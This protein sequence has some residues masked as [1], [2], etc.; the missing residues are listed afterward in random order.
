MAY[1][2]GFVCAVP[3]ANKQTY[4]DHVT[5]VWPMFRGYGAIRMVEAWGTDIPRGKVTDFHGAVNA[6]DDEAIVF[7][8]IE[9]P[10]KSTADAAWERMQGDPAM[11]DLP[12]MPFDAKRAI[13]GGFEPIL[14]E[15]T[16]R[17][18]GYL[19]GFILAVPGENKA[20]YTRVAREAWATAFQPYGCIGTVEAWGVDVPRGKQTDFHRAT[21]AEDG[22]VPLFS[23]TAWPDKPTCEAAAKAM[24]ADMEGQEYPEMPF[25]GMRMMWGGFEPIFDSDKAG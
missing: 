14:K 12:P 5:A 8:W 19:Q 2:S 16:D 18:A 4:I 6:Q 25:D 7:S 13:M 24:E 9:W 10:D 20:A 17:G 21:K 3:T 23:W 22:E 11:Q 1:Y 15:G